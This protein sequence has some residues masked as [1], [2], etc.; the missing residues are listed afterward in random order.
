[1]CTAYCDYF[2]K[3]EADASTVTVTLSVE[4]EVRRIANFRLSHKLHSLQCI[5]KNN[6][7]KVCTGIVFKYGGLHGRCFKSMHRAVCNL[8]QSVVDVS[9]R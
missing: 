5:T 2:R 1:M 4:D 9:L 6:E 8:S 7:A 3:E